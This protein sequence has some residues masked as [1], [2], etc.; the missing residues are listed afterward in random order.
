MY[1]VPQTNHEKCICLYLIRDII[2]FKINF[3][4]NNK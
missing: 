4:N 3:K 1:E 2:C